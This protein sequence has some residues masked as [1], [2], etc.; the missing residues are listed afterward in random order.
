V[1]RVLTPGGFLAVWIY[2]INYVEGKVPNEIVQDFYGNT[3]GPYW[4]PERKL[5]E[6]GYRDIELPY[7]EISVPPFRMQAE[8]SLEQLLGYF[9]T[10]S[11]VTRYKQV[12][13][14]DPIVR[15]RARLTPEWGEKARLI[16]WPLT[17]RIS[18]RPAGS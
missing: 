5:I 18:R 12:H 1:E 14:D 16:T 3:V 15:L 6:E 13:G 17:L 2:G 8:W 10:W 7:R 9:S 11:A 4:P